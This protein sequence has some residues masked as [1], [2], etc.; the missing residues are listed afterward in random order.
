[1][2]KLS[3]PP[4]AEVGE[5]LSQTA[6]QYHPSEAHG[7]MS[8]M[9]C[10]E[11]EASLQAILPVLTGDEGVSAAH[12]T[13]QGLYQGS[14]QQLA[15]FLFEFTLLMPDDEAPLAIRAEALT[16]WCQGFLTGLTMAGVAIEKREPSELTE[17]IGDLVE[18]A[19]MNYEQV[20]DSEE[21]EQAFAEL[22]EYV[23]MAVILI[24]Q[25]QTD[26]GDAHTESQDNLLH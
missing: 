21:D 23:R 9:L 18:I 17:A 25:S 20:V 4:F 19:K 1:M 2:K 26:S 8:G 6:L 10:G 5:A 7:L 14:T 3:L 24:F 16:L 13:L 11:K 15:Q 12:E 22:V